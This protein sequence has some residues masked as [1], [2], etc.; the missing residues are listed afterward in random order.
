MTSRQKLELRAGVIRGR[1][2]EIAGT[3]ELTDELRSEMDVLRVE[4]SDTERRISALAI[5]QDSGTRE[6]NTGADGEAAEFR[7]LRG[8]VESREYIAAAIEKRAVTGAALEFNQALSIA[9]TRFPMELLAPDEMRATTSVDTVT[10]PRRW[11]D[12]LFDETAAARLGITFESVEP[13]T[14]TYPVTTGGAAGV[15]RA[16]SEATTA[17]TWTVGV[18]ELK[19]T[20]NA[21]HVIYSMEDDARIPGMADALTR[22]MRMGIAESIDKAAFVGDSGATGTDAD[23]TGL[24]TASITE[25]TLTQTNKIK[26]SETLQAFTGMVDG[27]HA[28]G[29][30]DLRVVS[31]VGAWRLWE[32]TIIN[33]TADNQTLAGFLRTAGLSWS[34]RGGIDTATSAGDFGAYVGLGRGIE[35]A[36]VA[37]IWSDASLVTD[38][39]TSAAKGEVVLTL[40]YLWAFGL[41]RTSNFKRIKFVA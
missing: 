36:G 28:T 41:P 1:L 15:Q 22:D 3:D 7:A 2:A 5:S 23:I 4:Y 8:R 26:G 34:S 13:G 16:K 10:R 40:S 9:G 6:P 21:I 11:L 30:G 31:S 14:A 27:R 12:R 20:R 18:T 33:S 38:P 19:P 29:L 17:A 32:S 24:Q 39:Y 25:S 35:G 37:A